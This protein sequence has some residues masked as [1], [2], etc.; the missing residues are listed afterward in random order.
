[1]SELTVRDGSM[2][3]H[4][5]M[6]MDVRKQIVDLESQETNAKDLIKSEVM[7][8]AEAERVNGNYVS[9]IRIVPEDSAPVRAELRVTNGALNITDKPKLETLFG[10]AT[11]DLFEQDTQIGTI[12]DPQAI[13]DALKA[14]GIDPWSILGVIVKN[15]NIAIQAGAPYTQ[16]LVPK[17]GFMDTLCE[18]GNRLS[19]HISA[20][21]N[22]TLR[23]TVVLG[24]KG[25]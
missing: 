19:D 21:L 17:K 10:G 23:P 7:A 9:I 20:Y 15:G 3:L 6:A 22:H 11:D 18:L 8:M 5:K 25:K 13:I 14:K 4:A 2:A 16:V 24:T 12:V 1:M